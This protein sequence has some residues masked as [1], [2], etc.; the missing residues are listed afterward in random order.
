MHPPSHEE[1]MVYQMRKLRR[2]LRMLRYSVI[3]AAVG[4]SA[5]IALGAAAFSLAVV[6]TGLVVAVY[7]LAHGIKLVADGWDMAAMRWK[8]AKWQAERE[9][10]VNDEKI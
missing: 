9:K 3:F 2:E 6:A 5:V 4:I 10:A 1:M 8:R 7:C